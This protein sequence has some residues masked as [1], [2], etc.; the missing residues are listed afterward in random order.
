MSKP[1]ITRANSVIEGTRKSFTC[2]TT[3]QDHDIADITLP[4]SEPGSY[5]I[6]WTIAAEDLPVFTGS[7]PNRPLYTPLWCGVFGTE[8]S[9]LNY[10]VYINDVLNHSGTAGTVSSNTYNTLNI[11]CRGS[12]TQELKVG[13]V[14]GLKFWH[15][16]SISLLQWHSVCALRSAQVAKNNRVV[17]N[18]NFSTSYIA[19]GT[20]GAPD[21]YADSYRYNKLFGVNNAQYYDNGSGTITVTNASINLNN[22]TMWDL[23][24]GYNTSELISF[25]PGSSTVY[26]RNYKAMTISSMSWNEVIV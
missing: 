21:S 10:K 4:N 18:C 1:L 11:N 7:V 26:P 5:T 25:V 9:F 22:S 20:L 8:T 13:D 2:T 3:W 6:T 17:K 16:G 15:S 12:L 19:N 14:V 23:E 24:V